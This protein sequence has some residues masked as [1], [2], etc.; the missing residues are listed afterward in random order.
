MLE[1]SVN[2]TYIDSLIKDRETNKSCIEVWTLYDDKIYASPRVIMALKL[3]QYLVRII[4]LK[5]PI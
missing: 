1:I 3:I 2:K 5:S 4:N